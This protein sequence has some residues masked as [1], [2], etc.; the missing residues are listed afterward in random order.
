[1]SKNFFI[2]NQDI[3]FHIH[4]TIN[5][6]EIASLDP[7]SKEKIG[8]PI[9]EYWDFL[10]NLGRLC[11]EKIAPRAQEIDEEGVKF[12]DGEVVYPQGVLDNIEDLVKLGVFGATA[13]PEYGG[14][15]YPAVLD[16]IIL[17]LISRADASLF[18]AY[19]AT[20]GVSM[21]LNEH[22]SDKLIGMK[23]MVM[24]N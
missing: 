13:N 9:L 1:M 17:E 12:I 5:W 21:L 22:A 6:H 15:G 19:G 3:L 20:H 7:N 18:V 11:Y 16:A 2:D 10:T 8:S 24:T 4:N 14:K 23:E